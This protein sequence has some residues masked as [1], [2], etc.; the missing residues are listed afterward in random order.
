MQLSAE[1]EIVRQRELFTDK[2]K[3]FYRPNKAHL[4]Q[5]QPE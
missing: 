3:V 1:E 2:G 5:L 4:R